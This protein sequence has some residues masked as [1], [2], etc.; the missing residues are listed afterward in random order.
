[1]IVIC[2]KCGTHLDVGLEISGEAPCPSCGEAIDVD[3]LRSAVCPICGCGFEQSDTL[4]VCPDCKTPHHDECWT[5][6]RGCSTYGCRSAAHQETH[7]VEGGADDQNGEPGM[8]PCPACGA[9]HPATDLVCGAC[10][11]LL[12][13]DLPG[14]STGDRLKVK[15]GQLG[16][17]ARSELWPRIARNFRLL[18]RDIADVF[19]LWWGE[20]SRY[21]RF[22]G[23]TTRRGCVA[24]CGIN[25][26]I[27]W[28]F[29]ACEAT[30]LVVL[31]MGAVLLPTLAS[32]VRRLRD[33][34]VSPWL[35]FAVP[36]LPFLLLVPSVASGLPDET[37]D[38]QEE[39]PS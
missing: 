20:F 6:N 38:K 35:V 14:D 34:D 24:F 16:A 3:A 25:A 33:T 21:A 10:G 37:M 30:P 1:M 15:V 18:G 12:G 26:A 9:M 23:S 39:T 29:A 13:N 17:T 27:V 31:T 8:I 11:K 22:S 2:P 32:F 19:R 28:L 7:T 36:L 4:R 5:E